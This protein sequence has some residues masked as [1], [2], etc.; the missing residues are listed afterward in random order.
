[1]ARLTDHELA[2]LIANALHRTGPEGNPER[3]SLGAAYARATAVINAIHGAGA[4]V[5]REE[6]F[7]RAWEVLASAEADAAEAEESG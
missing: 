6:R 7:Q 2:S 5:I 1:M 4:V 3:A